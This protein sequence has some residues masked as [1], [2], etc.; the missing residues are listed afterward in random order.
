[1]SVVLAKTNEISREEWLKQRQKGIGGSDAAAILGINPWRSPIQVYMEKIGEIDPP[2]ENEAMYWG[3]RLEEVVAEEFSKR[4][5]L[6][7]RRRNAIL[8]HPG[9]PWMIA[10]VDR[11]IV[12]KKEGLECK[13]TNE[14]AKGEWEGDEV[15]APYLIQ[16]QHYMAV[17]GYDA[18]WIAVLIGGNKFVYKKINRD[19]ELIEYIIEAEKAFWENHVVP[20]VPPGFDGSDASAELLKKL[21]PEAEP[22]SETELPGEA[23]RLVEALDKINA[24]LKELEELKKE[25]E[26]TLKA[27]LGEFERGIAGDRIVTWK[28]V[29][30]KRLDTKRFRKDHP[31]LFEEYAKT[32]KY[33]RFQI[34]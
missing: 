28:T 20:R 33:R 30:S 23:C 31:E 5:G 15:P 27:M 32:T 9:H 22:E 4:T 3:T 10:N 34:S 7:I 19:E 6:K 11:L 12:G 14:F 1:M 17:T 24:E 21:Y 26:N 8:Q 13:T 25:Y 2:P 29:E 18:W 16:C